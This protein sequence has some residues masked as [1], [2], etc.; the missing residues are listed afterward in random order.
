MSRKH[1]ICGGILL[2]LLASSTFAQPASRPFNHF[3]DY[4]YISNH[5]TTIF[6]EIIWWWGNQYPGGPMHTND[7]QSLFG[8][9]AQLIDTVSTSMEFRRHPEAG[10]EELVFEHWPVA[11]FPENLD[12]L[13]DAAI[14]QGNFIDNDEGNLQTRLFA[15]NGQWHWHQWTQ[16]TLFDSSAI[17]ESGQIDFSLDQTI[18]V[19][20]ELELYGDSIQAIV[21][22]GAGG[23]I[24]L[25][26]NV[27][28]DG[29][30]PYHTYIHPSNP[31]FI[32]IT[33][34]QEIL[35]ADTYANGQ[36]N[37]RG[38]GNNNPDRVDIMITAALLALNEFF[39]FEHQN[40]SWDDYI[41]CD[42]DGEHPDENDERGYIKIRGSLANFR[43]GYVHRANCGEQDMKKI[44]YMTTVSV[45]IH[46]PTG[47]GSNGIVRLMNMLC[48][49]TLRS[50]IPGGMSRSYRGQA[51]PWD[52][53]PTST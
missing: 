12:I 29:V 19:E 15:H 20:G 44:T 7:E 24:R 1:G 21:S 26:D 51:L 14:E 46:H 6:N 37:G 8:Y 41:W 4:A 16:G 38:D 48:T 17:L 3:S 2:F 27:M 47:R 31:Y 34:E 36:G 25:M 18:F 45:I 9:P 40:D 35:V 23:N 28:I 42:P 39:T 43:R 22:I 52:R 30:R 5:E 53:E 10:P 49:V 33:S 50:M 11:V 32:G 13:R